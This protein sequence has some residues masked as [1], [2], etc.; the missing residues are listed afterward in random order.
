MIK[1]F[2]DRCGREINTCRHCLKLEIQ[3]E[4]YQGKNEFFI[5]TNCLTASKV[6]C[7]D[8]DDKLKEFFNCS[9]KSF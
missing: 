4:V 8:C 1:L 5:D 6:L 3:E 2:C 7:V 9:I